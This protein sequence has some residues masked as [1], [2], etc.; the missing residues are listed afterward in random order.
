MKTVKVKRL[1]AAGWK[2]GNAEDFL[3]SSSLIVARA[4]SDQVVTPM[5]DVPLSLEQR[6]EVYDPA[7][8][9]GEVMGTSEHAGADWKQRQ[10]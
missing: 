8:H 5:T 4:R 3:E 1:Q 7:R 10:K 2:V 6:L 9:G